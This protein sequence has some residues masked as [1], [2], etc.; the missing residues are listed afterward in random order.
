M[1]NR[2]C[3]QT[4]YRWGLS[5]SSG[6][7]HQ[8][9]CRHCLRLLAVTRMLARRSAQLGVAVPSPLVLQAAFPESPLEAL[10]HANWVRF[11]L[12]RWGNPHG[13]VIEPERLFYPYEN[14]LCLCLDAQAV[15]HGACGHVVLCK[16]W[17]NST[18]EK[19]GQ[20]IGSCST[21]LIILQLLTFFV[22]F[23]F[24]T[25]YIVKNVFFRSYVVNRKWGAHRRHRRAAVQ[26]T[27]LRPR[28]S[29]Q[30]TASVPSGGTPSMAVRSPRTLTEMARPAD[31]DAQE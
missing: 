22:L 29:T 25:C 21:L 31:V 14:G 2:R 11:K 18:F 16:S 23:S 12:L 4:P 28:T 15:Y 27:E 5:M 30:F 24:F 17:I 9:D 1:P 3:I 19:I 6:E 10:S 8:N 26:L 7:C 13:T 20:D